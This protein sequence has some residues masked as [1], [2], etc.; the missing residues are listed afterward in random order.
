M[1]NRYALRVDKKLI[2]KSCSVYLQVFLTLLLVVGSVVYM[3]LQNV[4]LYDKVRN[5]L[6]KMLTLVTVF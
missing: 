4:E 5:V 2:H 1:Y 3:I 6:V